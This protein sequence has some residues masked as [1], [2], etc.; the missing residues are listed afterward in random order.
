MCIRDRLWG[1]RAPE[2]WGQADDPVDFFDAKGDLEALLEAF[3]ATDL[4]IEP[5]VD[6]IFHPG[7]VA[8]LVDAAGR[9][10]GRLG[11]LHPSVEAELDTQLSAKEGVYLFELT[12][13][14]LLARTKPR[15]TALSKFPRVRRDLAVVVGQEVS[16]AAL[17]RA[18]YEALQENLVDFT[19][20]DVYTGKGIDSNEKSLALG[21]TL[22]APS[23]TLTEVE[24]SQFM[25]RVTQALRQQFGARLR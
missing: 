14:A 6:E 13:Q 17:E 18:V 11:R 5:G 7:Q 12:T 3:G 19:L 22:Q 15:F 8:Q 10:V 24:I 9:R 1:R 4:R 23:A 25:E 20:F 21:L 16:A 2:N